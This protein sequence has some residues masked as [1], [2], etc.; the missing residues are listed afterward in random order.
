[1][2][3]QLRIEQNGFYH[4]LN[5]GVA[6]QSIYHDK[7]DFLRFLQ[8]MQEASDEYGFE[9]FSYCFMDNH[10]HLLLKCIKSRGF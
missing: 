10:Y 6:K 2:P 5:R 7:D 3:R 8:I 4:V 9:I 1:L